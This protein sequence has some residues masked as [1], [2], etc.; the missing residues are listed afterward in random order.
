[1]T[2]QQAGSGSHPGERARRDRASLR[3][4]LG[5]ALGRTI[6]RV[7]ANGTP[8]AYH[9]PLAVWVLL[10][11]GPLALLA[12]NP[13]GCLAGLRAARLSSAQILRAE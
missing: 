5:L 11:I 6:W 12:A 4:P 10:V 9:P 7:V 13:A 1:M 3:V 2:R 8:V